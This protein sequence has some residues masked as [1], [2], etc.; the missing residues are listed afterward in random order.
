MLP[1]FKRRIG[2]RE[3]EGEVAAFRPGGGEGV[4]GGGERRVRAGHVQDDGDRA[5]TAGD[6]L[7]RRFVADHVGDEVRILDERGIVDERLRHPERTGVF[8]RELQAARMA[9]HHLRPALFRGVQ[10]VLHER[11][12][13]RKAL[14]AAGAERRNHERRRALG[15]VREKVEHAFV[16]YIGY[17]AVFRIDALFQFDLCGE[18]R[19]AL[20]RLQPGKELFERKGVVRRGFLRK[21]RQYAAERRFERA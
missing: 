20:R 14:L 1:D 3:R 10:G 11:P 6:A 9:A 7:G 12:A 5:R 16:G 19:A 2:D 21:A 13:L 18:H 17:E 4:R 8:G 15:I